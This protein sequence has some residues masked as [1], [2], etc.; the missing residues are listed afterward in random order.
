[1]RCANLAHG[2]SRVSG[3]ALGLS[4][5]SVL[6][7]KSPNTAGGAPPPPPPLLL[8]GEPRAPLTPTAPADDVLLQGK[9]P[10][11]PVVQVLQGDGQQVDGRFTC[12]GRENPREEGLFSGRRKTE[13][14]G[15]GCDDGAPGIWA[16]WG[17]SSAASVPSGL[18]VQ[19]GSQPEQASLERARS[20]TGHNGAHLEG[21]GFPGNQAPPLH[22]LG[23][24]RGGEKAGKSGSP[25]R[26]GSS[27]AFQPPHPT[28]PT[29]PTCS[30]SAASAPAKLAY[31]SSP[32]G[33]PACGPLLQR[34]SQRCPLGAQSR[35]ARL[36]RP[37]SWPVPRLG[38]RRTS[39][40]DPRGPHR[41]ARSA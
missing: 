19:G 29:C 22:L 11:G 3:E 36:R 2:L 1:M 14:G 9:L 33:G 34:T 31:L 17:L 6:L 8:G 38:R 41:P 16:G 40:W 5:R 10:G 4:N 20:P 25:P 37:L 39:C 7:P 28:Q 21:G 23:T 15:G 18:S 32:P 13:G 12:G 35:P 26:S 30:P 27:F 24:N